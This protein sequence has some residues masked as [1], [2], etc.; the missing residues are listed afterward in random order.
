M[1]NFWIDCLRLGGT[2]GTGQNCDGNGTLPDTSLT[3]CP[4]FYRSLPAS[5]DTRPTVAKKSFADC[6][7]NVRNRALCTGCLSLSSFKRRLL[8]AEGPR[9]KTSTRPAT[10]SVPKHSITD[11]EQKR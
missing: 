6:A 2:G 9:T 7:V 10:G 11:L 5:S 3:H 4:S 8:T 1:W